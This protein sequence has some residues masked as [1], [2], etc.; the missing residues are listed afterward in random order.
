MPCLLQRSN[1]ISY[2][3]PNIRLCVAVEIRITFKYMI[4]GVYVIYSIKCNITGCQTIQNR[5]LLKWAGGLHENFA[6]Y[7]GDHV[8]QMLLVPWN[9]PVPSRT[10]NRLETALQCN[11]IAGV[12]FNRLPWKSTL[13]T[14]LQ[15]MKNHLETFRICSRD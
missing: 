10:Y 4:V 15:F 5:D 12:I 8:Y 13:K 11:C 6:S 1:P 14:L 7:R 3:I 2:N 9:N